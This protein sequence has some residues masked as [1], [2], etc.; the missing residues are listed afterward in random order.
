MNQEESTETTL[1]NGPPH[2][3][4]ARP[5]AR[6]FAAVERERYVIEGELARGGLGRI[7]EAHDIALDRPVAI[8]ELIAPTP[9]SRA[10]FYREALVTARLQ[11]PS[12]VPVYEAGRW[13]SGDLFY[14]MRL[15]SGR[16]LRNLIEER[17]ALE[18]RLDLLPHVIAA[19]DSIAY[20]HSL[21]IIHRDIK[22]TNVMIGPFGETLVVD[23]G[24]AKDLAATE[25]HDGVDGHYDAAAQDL[26]SVGSIVGTLAY[27]APEQARGADVDERA[28]IYALG[29]LLYHVLTG[30]P[31]HPTRRDVQ[32]TSRDMQASVRA[33][34]PEPIEE[35]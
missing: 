15:I 30:R 16:T 24:V 22:P 11:H 28:D 23:W 19:A 17:S 29:A 3:R 35:I 26:T 6:E 27:M 5:R 1:S 34:P 32:D 18:G 10:R 9:T 14:V 12:I 33:A 31:P 20:A 13:P 25:G 7:L 4:P 2:P 21:R 8:K